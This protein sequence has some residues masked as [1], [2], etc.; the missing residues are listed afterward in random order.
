MI[1]ILPIDITGNPAIVYSSTVSLGTGDDPPVWSSASSWDPG[2]RAY[3]NTAPQKVYEVID[4]STIT[5]GGVSP[6][7]SVEQAV[8]KWAEIGYVNKWAMFDLSKNSSTVA[9]GSITVE[10]RPGARINSLAL[11]NLVNVTSVT[12]AGTDETGLSIYSVVG[13]SVT[14]GYYVV[15]NIPRV[16]TIRL[17]VTITGSGTIEVGSL[18]LGNYKYIGDIQDGI[19]VGSENFSNTE[20]DEFGNV[21][22]VK[23]R[24]VGRLQKSLF[25]YSEHINSVLAIRDQLNAKVAVWIG[26]YGNTDPNID[27]FFNATVLLGFYRAFDIEHASPVHAIVNLELEEL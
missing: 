8:P 12:I 24:E 14:N 7:I 6:A 16:S 26:L 23:R 22:L 13:A 5:S 3:V 20:R 19:S 4:L 10:L 15:T 11:L 25:L 2:D 17:T 9:S 18:V 1:V 27:N 21:A